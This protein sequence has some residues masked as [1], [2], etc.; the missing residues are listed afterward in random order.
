MWNGGRGGC[1][2][3]RQEV[4]HTNMQTIYVSIGNTDNRLTQQR[5]AEFWE[6][7]D[8]LIRAAASEV[9]GAWLSAPNAPFQ[10]ACW[11]LEATQ[12]NFVRLHVELQG[13][14]IAFE[15]ESIAW[16]NASVSFI[17]GVRA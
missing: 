10:N 4:T 17:E 1:Y 8:F 11:G 16:A 15:Q 12:A 6:A 3:A 2:T 7:T 13:I 9:H 14:A 5:W